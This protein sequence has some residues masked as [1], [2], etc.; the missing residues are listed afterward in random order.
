MTH[1]LSL[2]D[3]QLSL[4]LNAAKSVQPQWRSRYLKSVADRLTYLPRPVTN[5]DVSEAITSVTR[6][7]QMRTR[8]Q[9]A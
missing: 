3:Q 5:A 6:R 2:S 1:P 4:I 7:M 8:S 9:A